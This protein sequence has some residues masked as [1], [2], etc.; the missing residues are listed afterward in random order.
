MARGRNAPALFD[1]IH[2]A[3]RPPKASPT[4]GGVPTPKWWSKAGRPAERPAPDG[5]ADPDVDAPPESSGGTRRSWLAAARR[6]PE[7]PPTATEDVMDDADASPDPRPAESPVVITRIY[8]PPAHD[9]A[10][11]DEAEPEATDVGDP[12]ESPIFSRPP[13]PVDERPSRPERRPRP[14]SRRSSG[15]DAPFD[16]TADVAAADL[17]TSR[18]SPDD[19]PVPRPPRTSRRSAGPRPSALKPDVDP[20]LS[21][22][23]TAGEVR[24]RLSYA[25]AILAATILL[26]VLVIA[27]LAGT[28]AGGPTAD[29]A[30]DASAA[31]PAAAGS[32]MMAAVSTTSPSAA[33]EPTAPVLPATAAEP[34][35]AAEP[36][37]RQV[38]MMYVVM[39]SYPD[40]ETARRAADFLI[41]AGVPCDVVHSPSGVALRDWYSAV[42]L[43]A[44][45]RTAHGPAL[46]TYL[47]QLTALGPKFSG[48]A[49]DQFLPQPYIWRADSD[50]P[51][52]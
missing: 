13:E 47:Q 39:Q 41:R 34:A 4:G 31:A 37:A 16:P 3:K 14:A 18:W 19:E 26:L 25:G 38:G 52:P 6:S 36:V 12:D 44:F 51:R 9:V 49:Y 35:A 23:R 2:A 27:Y 7:P 15:T 50:A 42:G 48:K 33:A 5:S 40:R 30:A 21:F 28:R 46:Q 45:P 20:P 10:D 11:M 1:V 17:R 24:V 32:G 43:Q 8:P 29:S 22:D